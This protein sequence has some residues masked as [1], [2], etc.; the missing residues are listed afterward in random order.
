M[1]DIIGLAVPYGRHSVGGVDSGIV[2]CELIRPGA[3]ADVARMSRRLKDGKPIPLLLNHDRKQRLT[4]EV[5]LIDTGHALYFLARNVE[6]PDRRIRGVSINLTPL[7]AQRGMGL[8]KEVRRADLYEISLITSP[9]K[10]A[11]SG[12]YVEVLPDACR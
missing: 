6:L 3:F 10:P 11:Y 12:T 5:K 1:S 9:H 2:H 8:V 4:K 7:E